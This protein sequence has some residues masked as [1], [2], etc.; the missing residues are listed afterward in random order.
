MKQ[1]DAED[2]EKAHFGILR[3]EPAQSS[4]GESIMRRKPASGGGLSLVVTELRR[5]GV[6]VLVGHYADV[7][8]VE[9][10]FPSSKDLI[11]K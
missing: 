9:I 2:A 7:V 6:L 1:N 3:L 8:Y 11:D 10:Q 5:L 4:S